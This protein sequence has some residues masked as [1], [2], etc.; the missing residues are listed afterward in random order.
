MCFVGDPDEKHNLAKGFLAFSGA[1]T[2]YAWKE[3]STSVN[4]KDYADSNGEQYKYYY[5]E[6]GKITEEAQNL[7][8]DTILN[9]I[10]YF[11]S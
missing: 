8:K 11:F 4:G 6:D 9:V 5:G 3:R 10:E 2:V 1:K 7:E